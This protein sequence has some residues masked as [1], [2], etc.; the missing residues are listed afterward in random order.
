[1]KTFLQL[2]KR[3]LYRLTCWINYPTPRERMWG[4]YFCGKV[5]GRK[6]TLKELPITQVQPRQAP[7]P[8]EVHLRPGEWTRLYR[9]AHGLHKV[10]LE[11]QAAPPQDD[12]WLNSKPPVK[13]LLPDTTEEMP[14]VVKLLHER[15]YETRK[16]G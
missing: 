2:V 1:M 8:V 6:E 11:P 7:T 16:L 10:A 14:A 15:R 13:S 5:Q 3:T 12:S 9:E 4:M